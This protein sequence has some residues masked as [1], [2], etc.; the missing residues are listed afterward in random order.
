MRQLQTGAEITDVD[1]PAVEGNT[2]RAFMGQA[3]LAGVGVV[4]LGL[5]SSA[6]AAT[7]PQQPEAL[8]GHDYTMALPNA[9][10]EVQFRMGVIGPATLSRVTSEIAVD[11]AAD[12]HAKEFANFELR[13]GD[14]GE[15][16][17]CFSGPQV[18]YGLYAG[19]A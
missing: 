17:R 19:S 13:E 5:A 8:S 4:G 9:M 16:Q 18:R 6:K 12:A 11:K 7:M 14:A 2:R 1:R 15:D 10:N 3:A